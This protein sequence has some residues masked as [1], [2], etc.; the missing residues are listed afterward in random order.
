MVKYLTKDNNGR[1]GLKVGQ[2]G[3]N[4]ATENGHM[5]MVKYIIK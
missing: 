4:E 1:V 3:I 5:E 2:V